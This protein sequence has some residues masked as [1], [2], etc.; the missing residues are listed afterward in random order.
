MDWN[1]VKFLTMYKYK[2]SEKELPLDEKIKIIKK[3][4]QDKKSI[5]IVYLKSNDERSERIV[6]P[7]FIGEMEFNGKTFIGL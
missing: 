4:I 6:K 1:I 2:I 7:D 5:K 3:V